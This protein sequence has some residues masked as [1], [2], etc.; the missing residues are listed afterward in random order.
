MKFSK[1]ILLF[2][3]LSCSINSELDVTLNQSKEIVENEKTPFLAMRRTPCYGKC[4]TYKLNIFSNGDIIYQGIRFVEKLG[5]YKST[6][7]IKK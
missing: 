6:I 1:Y 5:L 3:L 2:F 7:D 4:P